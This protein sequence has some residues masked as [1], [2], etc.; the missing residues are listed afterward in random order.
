MSARDVNGMNGLQQ[1][2]AQL[3]DKD[4]QIKRTNE[5]LNTMLEALPIGVCLIEDRVVQWANC[6]LASTFGYVP[7]EMK[8]LHMLDLYAT[9]D[10]FDRIGEAVYPSRCDGYRVGEIRAKMK[11][12]CGEIFDAVLRVSFVED[13][14][15]TMVIAVIVDLNDVEGMFS[16]KDTNSK[17][18]SHKLE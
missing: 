13:A 1:L 11:R 17:T 18:S 16:E 7:E 6:A 5:I 8:G 12:K 14:P 15:E 9:P 4:K 2:T 3:I 10:E